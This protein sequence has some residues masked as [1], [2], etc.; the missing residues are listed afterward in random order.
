VI[1]TETKMGSPPLSELT[2]AVLL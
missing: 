1:F 2:F